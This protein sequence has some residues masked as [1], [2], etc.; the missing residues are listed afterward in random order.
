[1]AFADDDS[2]SLHVL[3]IGGDSKDADSHMRAG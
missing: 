1:M 3:Q 2:P